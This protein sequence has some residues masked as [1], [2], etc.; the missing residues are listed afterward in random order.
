MLLP[1]LARSKE[2]ARRIACI[3]DLK[4]LNL[5]LIM[6][7]HENDDQYPTRNVSSN[8]WPT[9]LYDGYQNVTILKCPSDVPNPATKGGLTIPDNAFRSYLMNGW[10]DYFGSM[11]PDRPIAEI[12]ILE[13]SETV[14][15]GEKESTSKHFWMDF[16][17]NAGN[18]ITQL[19]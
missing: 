19:E 15:I 3:N 13:P 10:N 17:G 6:Y 12:D 1:A 2:Q 14:T 9:L 8:S 5:S 16:L 11:T 7:I 4:Q 18:D